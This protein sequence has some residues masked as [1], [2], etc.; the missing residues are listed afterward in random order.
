MS[1]IKRVLIE[2]WM[3]YDA[4]HKD[5]L[6]TMLGSLSMPSFGIRIHFN[7]GGVGGSPKYIAN[8]WGG[9][10]AFYRFTVSGEEAV[11]VEWFVEFCKLIVSVGGE[12]ERGHAHDI[13]DGYKFVWRWVPVPML[14]GEAF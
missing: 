14:V 13:E 6:L 12:I 9:K 7:T 2:G 5:E 10:T 3:P 8:R 1:N 4:G 11:R